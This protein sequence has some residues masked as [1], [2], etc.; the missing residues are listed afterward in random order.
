VMAR[1]ARWT[2]SC[3]AALYALDVKRIQGAFAIS[4]TFG[5]KQR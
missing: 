2:R 1:A 4:G 3:M 5:S